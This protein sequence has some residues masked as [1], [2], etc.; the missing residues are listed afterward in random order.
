MNIG[1]AD[2]QDESD[3]IH[4]LKQDN[5]VHI[6]DYYCKD[7][8]D[9]G[10]FH[11]GKENGVIQCFIVF[12]FDD[13]NDYYIKQIYVG[14]PFQRQGRGTQLVEYAHEYLRQRGIHYVELVSVNSADPFWEEM[15]YTYH[16][17]KHIFQCKLNS[18]KD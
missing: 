6:F 13:D 15:G 14:S 18:N 9:K 4:L 5:N 11:V 3:I 10:A 1:P 17:T 7:A 8:L 2:P 16:Q 12:N